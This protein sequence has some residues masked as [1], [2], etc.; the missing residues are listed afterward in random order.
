[1]TVNQEHALAA[2]VADT[3]FFD[4]EQDAGDEPELVAD[5][6]TIMWSDDL[7]SQEVLVSL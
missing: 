1:M 3:A 4:G 5:G 7:Q 2:G 6:E